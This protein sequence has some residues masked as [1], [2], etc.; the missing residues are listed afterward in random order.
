MKGLDSYQIFAIPKTGNDAPRI[1]LIG[2]ND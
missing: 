1:L 2:V